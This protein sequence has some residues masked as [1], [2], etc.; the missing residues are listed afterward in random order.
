MSG[1]LSVVRIDFQLHTALHAWHLGCSFAGNARGVV[2]RRTM[3]SL[4]FCWTTFAAKAEPP[5]GRL[6]TISFHAQS[7]KANLLGDPADQKVEVYLPPS[8]DTA[9]G[10]R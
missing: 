5:K 8:Y 7:L 6:I 4:L 9:P 3:L 2:M 10:R 1:H